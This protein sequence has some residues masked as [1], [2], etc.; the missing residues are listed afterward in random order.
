MFD[1]VILNGKVIDG[2]CNGWF[3]ADVGIEGDRITHIGDIEPIEGDRVLDAEDLY[4]APGFIDIHAHSDYLLL[5]DPYAENKIYQGVTTDVSGNCG[6]SP[7]PFGRKWLVDW[8]VSEK[9]K[10]VKG[11]TIWTVDW[12]QAN[13]ICKKELGFELDWKDI[14]EYLCKQETTGTAVNYCQ[15]V[16]H[17]ALRAAVTGDVIRKTTAEELDEMKGLLEKAM[18]DGAYGF[19]CG[20]DIPQEVDAEELIELGKIVESYD[21]LFANHFR[22]LYFNEPNFPDIDFRESY[23]S[24]SVHEAIQIAERAG[25]R[26][27]IS[28]LTVDGKANWGKSEFELMMIDEARDRGIEILLDQIP[29]NA[30]SNYWR[31]NLIEILPDWI[32]NNNRREMLEELK[33][34]ETRLRILDELRKGVPGVRAARSIRRPFWED[35]MTIVHCGSTKEYEWKTIRAVAREKG[36]EE[37]EAIIELILENKGAVNVVWFTRSEVETIRIMQHPLTM[38]G[39]D[40]GILRSIERE[41]YGKDE[42]WNRIPNPRVYGTFPRVLGTYVREK[43]VLRLEDAIRKMTAAPALTMGIDDRGLLRKGFYADIVVFN[44][45]TVADTPSYVDWPS[46]YTKG[47]EHVIVNGGIALKDGKPTHELYGKVLRHK[48]DKN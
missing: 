15:L 11:E 17:H 18:I 19:S 44:L 6:F 3:K 37:E 21:G 38:F 16:G 35:A 39:S 40:G 34:P 41:M 14:G 13:E 7:G 23:P 31:T 8:W 29:F 36:V 5:A 22:P 27:T 26:M 48:K 47:I 2:T 25:V 46:T 4:V 10:D 45:E 12:D 24:I 20:F 28:H 43:K 32:L 42:A 1:L 9:P 33:K 30:G